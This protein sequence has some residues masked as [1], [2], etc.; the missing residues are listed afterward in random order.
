MILV[1]TGDGKGKSSACVGQTIRA[2]GQNMRVAFGQ[3]MKKDK[4]AGEQTMLARL[5][6]ENFYAGGRGFFRKE[7]ERPEHRQAAQETLAW[8]LQR[9]PAVDMLVLDE[10][11]YALSAQ[12]LTREEVEDLLH[13]AGEAGVH[14][15]LSGRNMPDW[16]G[17]AADLVTEM[18]EVKHPW[19]K[20]IA[21]TAGIEF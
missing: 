20:G 21:A 9:L 18:V 7:E 12:I 8:A 16:L 2:L 1:Y 15:V 5:L 14:V 4:Q 3:F 19:Q 11:L 10:T 17:E 6:G 13:K